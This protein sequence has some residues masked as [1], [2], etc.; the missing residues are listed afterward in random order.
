METITIK[1]S[2]MGLAIWISIVWEYVFP[3]T[4]WLINFYLL[5]KVDELID[6]LIAKGWVP[7][8]RRSRRSTWRRGR[9][10]EDQLNIWKR[11]NY[12]RDSGWG[13]GL[14]KIFIFLI[15]IK[16][17]YWNF[18]FFFQICCE[19]TF[20]IIEVLIKIGIIIY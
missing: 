16:L 9:R 13:K 12:L 17:T 5:I 11:I 4:W 19:F 10:L 18:F 1:V 20:Y 15:W 6:W 7:D 8:V 14:N 3:V 2:W